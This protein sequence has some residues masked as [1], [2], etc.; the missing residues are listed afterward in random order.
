MRS[1]AIT[2]L[3]DPVADSNPVTL[4]YFNTHSGPTGPTDEI[5]NASGFSRVKVNTNES[6]SLVAN[7]N[8]NLRIE[9]TLIVAA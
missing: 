8:E 6:I 2:N 5:V 1:Y 7:T 4:G 9:P 3:P